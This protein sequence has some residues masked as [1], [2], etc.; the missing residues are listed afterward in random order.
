MRID[1]QLVRSLLR[2]QFPEYAHLPIAQVVPGGHDNRTFRIG[3]HVAAR[4]PGAQPYAAHVPV[5]HEFLP[6]LAGRLPVRI[7]EPLGLG[8]PGCG[9]PWHWT[10]NRWIPGETGVSA[11]ARDLEPLAHDLAAFL[12]ALHA[13]DTIGAPR[14]GETNFH[15]GGDLAVYGDETE[16]LIDRLRGLIDARAA[17]RVWESARAS[18]W[19]RSPVWVHGDMAVDNFLLREGRLH[20][21]IDFGQLAAG[22][23]ACDLTLA[24][25]L[26]DER[27]S[28]TFKE[29]LHLDEDTWARA[30]GWALWKQLLNLDQA[31]QDDP[32]EVRRIR[33]VVARIT[34]LTWERA[35]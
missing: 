27:S 3:A 28:A 35:R 25:T 9:F 33:G 24:W 11:H 22:D 4:L 10:L 34:Y 17:T 13:I 1:S 19:D 26:L 14:P 5:E 12:T 21:V 23:P 6:R 18:R 16:T 15:R 32:D 31:L 30:R 7:P 20:A 2:A 8:E 29:R